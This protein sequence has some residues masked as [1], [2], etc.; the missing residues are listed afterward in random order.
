MDDQRLFSNAI[1]VLGKV[2]DFRSIRHNLIV[3]NIANMDTPRYQAKDLVFEDELK[4]ALHRGENRMI[5]THNRHFPMGVRDMED[6]K[7]RIMYCKNLILSNDLNTVD[8]EKEMGKLAENNLMYTIAAQIM[9]KK[10]EGLKNAI[11]EGGR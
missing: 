11:R 4:G 5:S 9:G 8:I 10:L 2:L 6:V 1:T 3:S 7:P